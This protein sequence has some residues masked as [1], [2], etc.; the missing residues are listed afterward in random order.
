MY[1]HFVV[2]MISLHGTPR[3]TDRKGERDDAAA[4]ATRASATVATTIGTRLICQFYTFGPA[5]GSAGEIGVPP[6]GGRLRRARQGSGITPER[7]SAETARAN[8]CLDRAGLAGETHG[9][10]RI[11]VDGVSVVWGLILAVLIRT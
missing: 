2:S 5:D 3:G 7:A 4:T 10:T 11:E 8:P 6:S 9:R 1:G